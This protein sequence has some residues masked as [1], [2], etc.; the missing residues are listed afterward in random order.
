[1]ALH[2]YRRHRSDCDAGRPN[3]FRSS[4]LDERRK[5]WGRRCRCLIQISGTLSG[6]FSRKTTSTADWTEARRIADAFEKAGS[7]TGDTPPVPE[8]PEPN[9]APAKTRISIADGCRV[10]LANRQSA[11]LAAATLRKYET[12]TNQIT[13]YAESKG[14]VFVDQITAD[15]IDLFWANWK[16]GPRAKGKRLTTLR[17]FFRF[18]VNRKWI[19]ESPVSSDIKAP[20]GSSKAAN[21]APFTDDEVKRI[22]AACDQVKVEW[23][24][25]TGLGIWTGEDLKDLIWLMLYTGFRISDA[26]LFS[27][28]RLHGE[29]VF[30]RAKK[31][32]GDVFAFVPDWLCDR[33]QTRAER[34]GERP[35]IVAR[36]DRLETITNIWRR[37]L[38]KAFD[39]AG[40]FEEPATPHRFRH[41]FARILLQRGVPVADVA[42]LLG[43]DEKTVR[44]HYARWVP[45]RQARLTKILKDAFQGQPKP[46]LTVLPGGRH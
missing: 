29:Q 32:G 35:F 18:C 10:F 15:D 5:G 30:I 13:A 4:E 1:M 38:A 3:E 11:N 8:V 7:W 26:T 20:V 43:D 14:Y 45:E 19:S 40:P 42:D 34:Y 36:S 24:N 16:L 23:K 46:A 44:E 6:K 21:K 9:S 28:K 41:T 37:R 31:N 33:L 12:F 2:L 27:M 22:I 39:V 17:G 25:E